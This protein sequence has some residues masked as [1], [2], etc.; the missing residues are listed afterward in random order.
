MSTNAEERNEKRNLDAN[1]QK[2]IVDLCGKLNYFC[3]HESGGDDNCCGCIFAEK[4]P[5]PLDTLYKE[6]TEKL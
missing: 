1:V 4:T 5:C 3:F 6:L 2:A